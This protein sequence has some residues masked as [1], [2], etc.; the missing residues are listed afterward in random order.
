[1]SRFSVGAF[2]KP[3][4]CFMAPLGV[5]NPR[6]NQISLFLRCNCCLLL[7]KGS[8]ECAKLVALRASRSSFLLV[9]LLVLLSSPLGGRR[10][11]AKLVALRAARC[12]KSG[13]IASS[14]PILLLLPPSPTA[15]R[16]LGFELSPATAGCSTS[17]STTARAGDARWLRPPPLLP[18]RKGG[19]W[20]GGRV[21]GC[22]G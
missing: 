20:T 9:L 11:S 7:L 6:Q 4:C 12:A 10:G 1:M 2:G 3:D 22:G 17:C 18:A 8:H 5:F 14:S 19:P 16:R 21:V 13:A 15:R